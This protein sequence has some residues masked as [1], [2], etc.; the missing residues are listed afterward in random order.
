MSISIALIALALGYKVFID[1]SKEKEGLRLLGQAIGVLVLIGSLLMFIA[2]LVKCAKYGC[3]SP[4]DGKYSS[5]CAMH[6]NM[7]GQNY[8]KNAWC[9]IPRDGLYS[10]AKN[11][12]QQ[13][14]P[15][16]CPLSAE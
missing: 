15:P 14:S 8:S 9:G 2:G 7:A 6:G 4:Y 13:N 12:S 5:L 10:D 1:A 3:A 11:K 16:V